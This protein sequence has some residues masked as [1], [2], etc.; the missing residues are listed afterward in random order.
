MAKGVRG[1]VNMEVRSSHPGRHRSTSTLHARYTVG[2][3]FR[4]EVPF[5]EHAPSIAQV[6]RIL[7][8]TFEDCAAV[9]Q[10]P[11]PIAHREMRA[12][13]TSDCWT[14][15]PQEV[16]EDLSRKTSTADRDSAIREVERA[17]YNEFLP[18]AGPRTDK[19]N[20]LSR[21]HFLRWAFIA[22]RDVAMGL[23]LPTDKDHFENKKFTAC[24]ELIVQQLR[25]LL[26]ARPVSYTHLTL[27]TI[28]SV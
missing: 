17:I 16:I 22:M 15:R 20:V 7:G 27:P 3:E 23:R 2:G 11:D 6:F 25:L 9:F 12:L 14:K 24:G 5:L 21:L 8:L 13:I 28:C 1:R 18:H 26:R 19:D 10:S 4:L